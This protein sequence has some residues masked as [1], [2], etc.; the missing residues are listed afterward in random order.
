M[1]YKLN[2]LLIVILVFLTLPVFAGPVHAD[3]AS[4][5]Q[6]T[7]I[8]LDIKFEGD[9]PADRPKSITVELYRS[10]DGQEVPIDSRTLSAKDASGS[11]WSTIFTGLDGPSYEYAFHVTGADSITDLY[12][13]AFSETGAGTDR[14]TFE[15]ALGTGSTKM[16]IEVDWNDDGDKAESRPDYYELNLF[17]LS[18]PSDQPERTLTLTRSNAAS[19]DPNVWRATVSGLEDDPANYAVSPVSQPADYVNRVT[20]GEKQNIYIMTN[21]YV[22]QEALSGSG[23]EAQVLS[24]AIGA[25][26]FYGLSKKSL[27][28]N[29]L[30]S[31]LIGAVIVLS[32]VL[33][34]KH[35]RIVQ[36][37]RTKKK[38]RP[39]KRGKD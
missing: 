13:Y 8:A 11:T 15:Y 29:M 7:V 38:G 39:G 26:R 9:K 3:D 21:T 37:M 10:V 22:P 18:N 28:V 19:S 33:I 36:E 31:V 2:R 6:G 24:S 14:R 20:R 5:N 4:G 34:R 23:S 17:S 16:E 1:K 12:K 32:A 27:P 30:N 35:R 25:V